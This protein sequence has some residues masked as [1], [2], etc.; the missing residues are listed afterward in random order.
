MK[1]AGVSSQDCV[2]ACGALVAVPLGRWALKLL[3]LSGSATKTPQ[4]STQSCDGTPHW[5]PLRAYSKE[6][7]ALKA[8]WGCSS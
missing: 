1:V 4:A 2:L 3:S 8:R 5:Q 6:Y 7:T